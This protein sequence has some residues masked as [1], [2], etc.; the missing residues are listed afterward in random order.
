MSVD[1]IN[2]FKTINE[3]EEYR[4]KMNEECDRRANLISVYTKAGELSNKNFGAIKEAF[5]TIS[6]ELFKTNEGKA[7]MKKYAKTIKDSNNLK[8][9]HSLYENIRKAN[10]NGDVDFFV[11]GI[12][13]ENWGVDK[14]TVDNDCKKLGRVLAEGY[15]LINGNAI[16][17]KSDD[18]LANA[19]KFISENVKSAKN[20]AE[21][22]DAVKVI[23][24][25][26]NNHEQ[27]NN[28]FESRNIDDIA[29]EMVDEFNKKYSTELNESE[30]KA[31][32]EVSCS[33]DRASVFN[34]Y[35]ELC[36]NKLS[37]AKENFD[38]EQNT[39]AS[40]KISTII[41]QVSNKSYSVDTVGNDICG[42]IELANI[43]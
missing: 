7:I 37:E 8:A 11:N 19:V 30:F 3:V 32:K 28:V 27:S 42:M 13:S 34:K 1:K 18:T 23:R 36:V 21:Y 2:T 33:D 31:L 20:I 15:I 41:E 6:P 10:A 43:F 35:K 22:S 26:V 24:D 12:A 40:E 38:K 14:K 39:A 9:L 29:K 16:L 25:R 4:K 17:P 5:E